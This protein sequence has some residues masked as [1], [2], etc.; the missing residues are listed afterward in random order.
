[1]VGIY[2]YY[3]AS[4]SYRG[5]NFGLLEGT[6]GLLIVKTG[7]GGSIYGY[8]EKYLKLGV[9]IKEKYAMSVIVSDNPLEISSLDNMVVT[10]AVADKYRKEKSISQ[11]YYFGVSKG[12]QYAA[13]YGYRY[14]WV[15]KW[16]SLNMPL[17]INWHQS[18][19]G[20]EQLLHP[21]NMILLFGDRDPSYPYVEIIDTVNNDNIKKVIIPNADHNLS[22]G[23]E[24]FLSLPEK[25]LFS[26]KDN[27]V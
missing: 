24:E 1:M 20:L 4:L 26:N 9:R 27:V 19:E 8:G 14:K 10:M 13:M 15:S 5:I 18:K 21:Q 12:G 6:E 22:G 3:D 23:I 7:S 16:L 17:F 2:V 25:H 11:V